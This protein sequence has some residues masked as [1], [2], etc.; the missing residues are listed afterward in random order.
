VLLECTG[1]ATG[2]RRIEAVAEKWA[3][4]GHGE[5]LQ[6]MHGGAPS[7]RHL[8][9]ALLGIITPLRSRADPRKLVAMAVDVARV[10]A[11]CALEYLNECREGQTR[12]EPGHSEF[13]A[14][15]EP[16]YNTNTSGPPSDSSTTSSWTAAA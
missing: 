5:L 10:A 9:A 1:T 4:Q 16:K 8:L 12:F 7:P 11:N 6:W 13:H 14:N 2:R 3:K 15:P